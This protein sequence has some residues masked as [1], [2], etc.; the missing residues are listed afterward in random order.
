MLL[1]EHTRVA[2]SKRGKCK[3]VQSSRNWRWCPERLSFCKGNAYCS[4]HRTKKPCFYHSKACE[5]LTC[6]QTGMKIAQKPE[7]IFNR[8]IVVFYQLNCCKT[9]WTGAWAL[10][11]D[12]RSAA[13][14]WNKKEELAPS[15]SPEGQ[16]LLEDLTVIRWTPP[17]V[18]SYLCAHQHLLIQ[19]ILVSCFRRSPAAADLGFPT[20]F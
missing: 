14:P 17:S 2:W 4:Y 5:F 6:A 19:V 1:S 11:S 9:W 16:K 13:L 3:P 7:V 18:S 20:P 15:L 8:D 10:P 12:S